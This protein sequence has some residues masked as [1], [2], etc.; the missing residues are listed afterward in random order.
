M[1]ERAS[2]AQPDLLNPRLKTI[3]ALLAKLDGQGSA[4]LV[5]SVLALPG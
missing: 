2:A 5:L 1:Q 4:A 3:A